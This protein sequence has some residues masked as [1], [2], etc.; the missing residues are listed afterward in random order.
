MLCAPGSSP[1][2]SRCLTEHRALRDVPQ[3]ISKYRYIGF[4][5]R[6]TCTPIF[7]LVNYLSCPSQSLRRS[8]KIN[9]FSICTSRC[10]AEHLE[11]R[12]HIVGWPGLIHNIQTEYFSQNRIGNRIICNTESRSSRCST[13]HL[14]EHFRT[15]LNIFIEIPL[16]PPLPTSTTPYSPPLPFPSP[17]PRGTGVHWLRPDKA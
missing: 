14:E 5:I 3:D 2:T 17:P 8:K 11:E 1:D 9:I 12:R 16:S 15:E 4:I 7:N 13:G 10:P 6:Y